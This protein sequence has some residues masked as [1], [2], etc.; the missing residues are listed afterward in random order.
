MRTMQAAL[1]LLGLAAALGYAQS[2]VYKWTDKDGKVH[3]TDAPPP[4]DAKDAMQKRMGGGGPEDASLPYA[5]QMA[6]RRNPVSLFTTSDCGD[7]CS[8]ARDLLEKR[9]VP[10]TEHNP[11]G[12]KADLDQLKSLTGELFVP[13]LVVGSTSLKGFDEGRWNSSLDSAGYLRTKLPSQG[14]MRRGPPPEAAKPDTPQ[15]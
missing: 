9:G 15:K 13:T 8:S 2:N 14:S 10:Y 11:M 3:F 5:T 6:V 4:D 7:P 1:V 12:S